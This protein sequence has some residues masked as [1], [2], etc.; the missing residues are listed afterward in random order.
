MMRGMGNMQGMMKQV[1]KMQKEMG[2]AQEKLNETEF[3]GSSTNDLVKVVFT[4]NRRMKDIQ[5]NDEVVDPED[6]EML[7]DLIVMAVNDVLEK[8]DKE[9]EK[10]MGKY[11]KGLPF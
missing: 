11:T 5:I 1:Q 7:Q 2:E 10:T 9:S 4:G 3:T 8:I 6:T